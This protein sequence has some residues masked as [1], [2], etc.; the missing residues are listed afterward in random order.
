ML[1]MYF[2]HDKLWYGEPKV[3]PGLSLGVKIYNA[4]LTLLYLYASP[5]KAASLSL[6]TL[7]VFICA[8]LNFKFAWATSVLPPSHP[9]GDFIVTVLTRLFNFYF[10]ILR[11]LVCC[12]FFCIS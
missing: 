5:N 2:I 12:I 3:A 6:A 7:Y 1:H 9:S 11:D 8:T 10:W 4:T